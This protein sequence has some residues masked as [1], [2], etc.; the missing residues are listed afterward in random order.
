MMPGLNYK[1]VNDSKSNP[2]ELVKR[3]IGTQL[4]IYDPPIFG[5]ELEGTVVRVV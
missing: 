5:R 3:A 1:G 4:F 2:L